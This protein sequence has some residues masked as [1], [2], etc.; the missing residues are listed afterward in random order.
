MNHSSGDYGWEKHSKNLVIVRAG[1][2]SLHEQ[3]LEGDCER[4]FDLVV[5]YF[6][7]SPNRYRDLRYV[8]F[9]AEGPFAGGPKWPALHDFVR[10]WNHL[11][12][13]YDF[14]WFPD[15]DLA[16]DCP[17]IARMFD[18]CAALQLDLA[19]PALTPDSYLSHPITLVNR[20]FLVR[21]TN[22]VE[23]MAPAFSRDFLQRCAPAFNENLSGYGLDYLW[24]TWITTPEKVA[25]LDACTIRH[26]RPVGG[27]IYQAIAAHGKSAHEELTAL[28]KKYGLANVAAAVSGGI[29]RQGHRLSL[30]EGHG[31]D[32]V[33]AILRGY[34]PELADDGAALVRLLRPILRAMAPATPQAAPVDSNATTPPATAMGRHAAQLLGAGD[35]A[36][37][38]RILEPELRKQPTADLWNDWATARLGCGDAARAES[39]FRNSLR[40]DP[41]HRQ[42]AVNLAVLLMAQGRLEESVPVLKP[43]AGSLTEEEKAAIANLVAGAGSQNSGE[44]ACR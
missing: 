1:D 5:I 17:T 12:E 13:E 23:I 7:D 36:A 42:A 11:I 30:A 16:A 33:A 24:P 6:A 27:P 19:Q 18:L 8:R 20:S 15:D 32:L 28:L 14:V 35:P 38:V 40:L 37:A 26:T 34:L 43:H 31:E 10:Q 22:F 2:T 41:C 9:N 29:D 25:I 21:Y 4:N 44:L 3:W 39:G